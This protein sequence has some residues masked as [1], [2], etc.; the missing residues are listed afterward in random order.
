MKTIF[1]SEYFQYS[2]ENKKKSYKPIFNIE[3]QLQE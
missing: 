3:L 1:G 2:T